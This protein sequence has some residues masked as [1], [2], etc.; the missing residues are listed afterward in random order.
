M[1]TGS[2]ESIE[3]RIPMGR[4]HGVSERG[5]L[6]GIR[7]GSWLDGERGKASNDVE[8]LRASTI[9]ARRV[10]LVPNVKY[11]GAQVSASL[12]DM[13]TQ[14]RREGRPTTFGKVW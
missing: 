12:Q 9:T 3:P 7:S 11:Q 6:R 10:E 4:A 2:S 8:S 13:G 1:A 14:T 5:N